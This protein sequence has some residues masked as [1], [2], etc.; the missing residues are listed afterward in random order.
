MANDEY[1]FDDD[2][3]FDE[4]SD[5]STPDIREGK[6]S[7]PRR[8]V[9]SGKSLAKSIGKGVFSGLKSGLED[10]FP[11]TSELVSEVVSVK[12]DIVNLKEDLMKELGPTLETMSTIGA[13]VLPQVETFVPKRIYDKAYEFLKAHGEDEDALSDA[14]RLEQERENIISTAISEAFATKMEQDSDI[15]ADEK[16]E[17][18][19]DR[20]I[21][22]AR[23]NAS[24]AVMSSI[25]SRLE[26]ISTFMAGSATNYYKASLEL[27]YK[28][29]FVSKDTHDLLKGSLTTALKTLEEIKHNAGLPDSAK[30]K[31]LKARQS[32]ISQMLG[33]RVTNLRSSF[34]KNV[35]KSVMDSLESVTSIVPA[36]DMVTSMMGMMDDE[37]SKLTPMKLVEMASGFLASMNAKIFVDNYFGEGLAKDVRRVTESRMEDMK[38]RGSLALFRQAKK[39][40]S[41]GGVLGWL[42]EQITGSMGATTKTAIA[43]TLFDQADQPTEFDNITKDAIISVIPRHLEHIGSHVERLSVKLADDI[44]LV[45][46]RVDPST[47]VLTESSAVLKSMMMKART[48]AGFSDT[49]RHDTL[50]KFMYGMTHIRKLE[51][52]D[53][54]IK[55]RF[56]Q[57]KGDLNK[58]VNN[59]ATWLEGLWE[60]KEILEFHKS[61][62][63]TNYTLKAFEGIDNPAGLA[64]FIVG[65]VYDENEKLNMVSN[66]AIAKAI[67]TETKNMAPAKLARFAEKHQIKDLLISQGAYDV[68][69][70]QMTPG[71]LHELYTTTAPRLEEYRKRVG[72]KDLGALEDENNYADKWRMHDY[73]NLQEHV[74]RIRE[75]IA[76]REAEGDDSAQLKALKTLIGDM[77]LQDTMRD[78]LKPVSDTISKVKGSFTRGLDDVYQTSSKANIVRERAPKAKL[79]IIKRVDHTS[80]ELTLD[81][82]YKSDK[83]YDY[84]KIAITIKHSPCSTEE[85][86]E[87]DI[88]TALTKTAKNNPVSNRLHS[89]KSD[90]NYFPVE[91]DFDT[92][93]VLVKKDAKLS[94][95]PFSFDKTAK[96]RSPIRVRPKLRLKRDMDPTPS[97]RDDDADTPGIDGSVVVQH[98]TGKLETLFSDV[99]RDKN[100]QRA[101]RLDANVQKV[102]DGVGEILEQVLKQSTKQQ[103]LPVAIGPEDTNTLLAEFHSHFLEFSVLQISL[104]KEL[105]NKDFYFFGP[106]GK[107]ITNFMRSTKHH[108]K[109]KTKK[110]AKLAV[111]GY[112]KTLGAAYKVTDALFTHVP[113]MYG[114]AKNIVKSILPSKET[115]LETGAKIKDAAIGYGRTVKD[116]GVGAYDK[117]KAGIKKITPGVKTAGRWSWDKLRENPELA[118]GALMGGLVGGG[119]PGAAIGAGIGSVVASLDKRV[120]SGVSRFFAKYVDVF[121]KGKP[122]IPGKPLLSAAKQKEGVYFADGKRLKRSRD[123]DAPI[124]GATEDKTVDTSAALITQ[125][126]I[127]N[128]L[129]DIRGKYI[130][131]KK[132]GGEDDKDELSLGAYTGHTII[133]SLAHIYKG[134]TGLLFGALKK[135]GKATSTILGRIF[136]IE[137]A[138]IKEYHDTV[139]NYL[140][141]MHEVIVNSRYL[142][143]PKIEGDL[144]HDGDRDGS[145]EDQLEQIRAKKLSVGLGDSD[146][147]KYDKDGKLISGTPIE[148]GGRVKGFITN[149]L[150]TGLSSAIFTPIMLSL[151]GAIISTLG[152]VAVPAAILAGGAAV[153]GASYFTMK[154]FLDTVDDDA[155]IRE[156]L[157]LDPNEKITLRDRLDA[158]DSALARKLKL[159]KWMPGYKKMASWRAKSRDSLPL[160]DEQISAFRNELL[161]RVEEGDAAASQILE[162]FDRAVENKSWRY[163]R[164]LSGLNRASDKVVHKKAERDPVY[165]GSR[166]DFKLETEVDSNIGRRV[167]LILN[168]ITRLLSPES[169]QYMSRKSIKEVERIQGVVKGLKGSE[170]NNQVLDSI[171]VEL[172]KINTGS[173]IKR[174]RIGDISE[175]AVDRQRYMEVQK[176]KLIERRARLLDSINLSISKNADR[177]QRAN[178]R[179]LNAIKA[180]VE[181]I[182]LTSLD[183][184]ILNYYDKAVLRIDKTALP[185]SHEH[186]IAE[187]VDKR[188]DQLDKLKKRL[189]DLLKNTKEGDYGH[190]TLSMLLE[191]ASVDPSTVD[192]HYV[193]NLNS[194]V[195]R[196]AKHIGKHNLE[197]NPMWDKTGYMQQDESTNLEL[198]EEHA[199]S[200]DNLHRLRAVSRGTSNKVNI[201][202][203]LGGSIIHTHPGGTGLSSQDMAAAMYGGLNTITAITPGSMVETY[204][205]L[206]DTIKTTN[207]KPD[208]KP[209]PISFDTASIEQGLEGLH[210]AETTQVD[211]LNIV[212]EKL[213]LLITAVLQSKDIIDGKIQTAATV[214][215]AAANNASNIQLKKAMA[216]PPKTMRG[217]ELNIYK[218]KI[219]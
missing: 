115:I 90:T 169:R 185:S 42:G 4:D 62:T 215:A 57:Y 189:N 7:R 51:A 198:K 102:S 83:G 212:I 129:V 18:Q 85:V 67:F 55:E 125:E 126:Q 201:P 71:F 181:A 193:S 110:A 11:N 39:W 16:K 127:D 122:R 148:E 219:A 103:S 26:F 105:L 66:D 145:A 80:T 195:K 171:A 200:F 107:S 203:Y 81:V 38:D 157:N 217:S 91:Y 75:E 131:P 63:H 172:A 176:A 209:D 205:T 2:F 164:T 114:G 14:K 168:E 135:G 1:D 27:K 111:K 98:I 132:K 74:D 79:L 194:L 35:K 33:D 96:P 37:D 76:K 45:N 179:D 84:R 119:I 52:P 104:M 8:I 121:E 191:Q 12:D 86:P 186:I 99:D 46:R 147:P 174:V 173:M 20:L 163:A 161:A 43:D 53:K 19:V 159:D 40:A 82:P 73:R 70:Q 155:T 216:A 123:I 65:S 149:A 109:D 156:L 166:R 218:T 69:K 41:E 87:Q 140:K 24:S 32:V 28:H 204:S 15:V 190:G 89:R 3:L 128:G 93:E 88:R 187:G 9:R 213:E 208:A 101:T 64:S 44:E 130:G 30:A 56:E 202:G 167:T 141:D 192:D 118:L 197:T 144:D 21:D 158:A 92:V 206:T 5:S 138:E 120:L 47:G 143:V 165:H 49:A 175:V 139:T 116:F 25:D 146:S 137:G 124:F 196:V 162:D 10:N 54:E 177:K 210:E 207:L 106:L 178:V 112:G 113:T 17:K 133:D 58:L 60:P 59:I 23:F 34:F 184:E 22:S 160:T 134:V 61:G 180:N 136:G 50:T 214:A 150:A 188:A 31:D 72:D 153:A 68:G 29:M 77:E 94:Y 152:A 6:V 108:V 36:L 100:E 13:R 151:K 154:N 117:T 170:L 95:V 211:Q 183:D 48:T 78:V 97:I 142:A 182:S 199:L